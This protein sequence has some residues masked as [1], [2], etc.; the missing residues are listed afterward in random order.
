MA[1][2]FGLKNYSGENITMSSAGAESIHGAFT[3]S[4]EHKKNY[5][6]DRHTQGGV[7]IGIRG[8]VENFGK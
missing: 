6:L 1:A 8:S 4:T 3:T 5:L 7:A 2:S